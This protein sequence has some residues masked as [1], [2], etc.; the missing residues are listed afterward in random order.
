MISSNLRIKLIFLVKI[1]IIYFIL[2]TKSY[3][4]DSKI[5]KSLVTIGSYDATVKIKIFSSLTCPHCASF[6][7]E[8]VPEIMKKFVETGKAQL[9]FIDFPLD[10]AAFNASKLLHCIDQKKQIIFL[11]TIYETQE[12]WTSGS[13]IEDINENLK[14]IVKNL[15]INSSQFDE[16]LIDEA[17]SDKILNGRIKAN[18]KY[19]INSTPTI[20]INEKKLEGS[21]SFKNI[22]KRIEKII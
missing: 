8:V 22:K 2:S 17:I 16:C 5:D 1:L 20:I 6:H 7:S 21:V 11:D 10:L 19:S 14:K 13:G 3:A 9:I 18:K 15:G 12:S 4:E